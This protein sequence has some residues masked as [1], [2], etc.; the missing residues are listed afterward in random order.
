MGANVY[1]LPLMVYIKSLSTRYTL[2]IKDWIGFNPSHGNAFHS[3]HQ[4]RTLII[5][6]SIEGGIIYI[7]SE[8]GAMDVVIS[9]LGQWRTE[10]KRMR[11][12]GKRMIHKC[13]RDMDEATEREKD[14]E[15]C[16]LGSERRRRSLKGLV[17]QMAEEIDGH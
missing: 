5:S 17:E 16:F 15:E 13:S 10:K 12:Q 6:L 8:N 4:S 7:C 2:L 11:R 1:I 9:R 3:P 14:L